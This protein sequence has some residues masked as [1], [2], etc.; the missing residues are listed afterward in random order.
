M[1]AGQGELGGIV[2]EL[3]AEPLSRVVAQLAVLRVAGCDVIGVG[4]ALVVL[5]M[6]RYAIGAECRILPVSV[7]QSTSDRGVRASQRK[8]GRV[9]IELGT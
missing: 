7:A 9:V 2:I 8:L 5:Q 3:S 6:A 4:G 1:R